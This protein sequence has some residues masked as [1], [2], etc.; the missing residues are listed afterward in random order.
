MVNKMKEAEVQEE[1]HSGMKLI[2]AW[3]GV[4]KINRSWTGEDIG[5]LTRPWRLQFLCNRIARKSCDKQLSQIS[6]GK[7]SYIKVYLGMVMYIVINAVINVIL[8]FINVIL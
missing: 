1:I 2:V 5:G 8:V 3:R 4:H 6:H 7:M